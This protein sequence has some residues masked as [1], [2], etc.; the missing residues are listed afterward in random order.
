MGFTYKGVRQIFR[1]IEP[2]AFLMGSPENEPERYADEIQ[3]QVSISQG[4]WLAETTVTQALWMAVIGENPSRFQGENRPV[5]NISWEDAQVFISK[6]NGMKPELRLCLPTEAQWEY[7]CRAGTQT[8]FAF[9][10]QIDTSLVNFDGTE[11]YNHAKPSEYRHETVSVKSLPVNDWGLYE[12]HGNVLEWCGDWYWAYS[13]EQIIDPAGPETGGYKVVLGSME[14][15][16]VAPP[17]VFTPRLTTAMTALD[18]AWPE[19][20]ETDAG[21]FRNFGL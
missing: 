19:V 7:A 20:I 2:G 4:F 3:H 6:M 13:T 18:F 5:E 1:W 15:V 17:T 8:P 9:G 11:P 14:A 12:M 21:C 10:E 16:T